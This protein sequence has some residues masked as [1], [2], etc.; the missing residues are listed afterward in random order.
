MPVPEFL[1]SKFNIPQKKSSPV[2]SSEI[3]PRDLEKFFTTGLQP[4]TE[5][6]KASLVPT[7]QNESPNYFFQGLRE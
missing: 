5:M 4:Q 3:P 2:G 7:F 1:L 6:C